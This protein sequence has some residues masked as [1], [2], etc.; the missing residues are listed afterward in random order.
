MMIYN[1]TD[2][3]SELTGIVRWFDATKG[4]GFLLDDSNDKDYYVHITQCIDK[5]QK[6]DK[7]SFSLVSNHRGLQA[8]SVKLIKQ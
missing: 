8:A 7:V 1:K 5:I 4:Y 3:M 6:N 2:F